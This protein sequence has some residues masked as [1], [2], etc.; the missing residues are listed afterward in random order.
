[1]VASERH[2]SNT[3]SVADPGRPRG[4]CPHSPRPV[5]I[6]HK[7]DCRRRGPH[8]FHVS[9][10]LHYWTAGSATGHSPDMMARNRD[11]GRSKEA[12]GIRA[13]WGVQILSFSCSFR[14]KLQNNRELAPDLGQHHIS[15]ILLNITGLNKLASYEVSNWLLHH[16][17][18]EYL[19]SKYHGR[20]PWE[21]LNPCC[22]KSNISCLHSK[23]QI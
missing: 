8:I 10:P 1:M 13:P 2:L 4:P 6:S 9:C 18:K 15:D 16:F 19:F 23:F 12:L 5:K 17:E 11:S 7:K 20:H 22:S 3:L 14:K 21:L